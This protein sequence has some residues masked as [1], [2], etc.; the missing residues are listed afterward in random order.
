MLTLTLHND[1]D[2]EMP[3]S[4]CDGWKLIPFNSN[5]VGYEDP[6]EYIAGVN[7]YG[8]VIPAN[9]GIR[10]KLKTGTAWFAERYEHGNSVWSLIGEGPRCRF[11]TTRHAGIL[12]WTGKP[13]EMPAD[14]REKSARMFLETYTCWANGEGHGYTIEDEDG[15]HVDSCFGFFGN[16]MDYM[17]EQ[18][19]E[20]TGTQEVEVGGEA[21]WLADYHEVNEK[22]TPVFCGK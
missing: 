5:L 18:I 17:F 4:G 10:R 13:K 20:H 22:L 14:M 16:D 9:I 8:E 12:V 11:D 21:D 7:E 15:E 2:I 19:R 6:S 3:D 1:I